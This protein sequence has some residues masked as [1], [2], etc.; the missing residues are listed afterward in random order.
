ME[1]RIRLNRKTG[2]VRLAAVDFVGGSPLTTGYPVEFHRQQ[3]HIVATELADE[4]RAK[5]PKRKS[6]GY[7]AIRGNT[8]NGN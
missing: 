3:V 1:L 2:G 7:P 4:H 8:A 6:K 5:F